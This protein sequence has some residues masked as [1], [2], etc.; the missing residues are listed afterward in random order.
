MTQDDAKY[1]PIDPQEFLSHIEL[2]EN[3]RGKT[4]SYETHMLMMGSISQAIAA[5]AHE[6]THEV[7]PH[8]LLDRIEKWLEHL[9]AEVS[10]VQNPDGLRNQVRLLRQSTEMWMERFQ[11]RADRMSDRE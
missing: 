6:D 10:G 3:V 1:I 7:T 5:A 11:E 8:W 4:I 9:M 2:L